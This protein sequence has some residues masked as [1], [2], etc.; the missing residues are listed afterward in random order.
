M[1]YFTLFDLFSV[2]MYSDMVSCPLAYITVGRPNKNI[3]SLD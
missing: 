2:V 1:A 3:F